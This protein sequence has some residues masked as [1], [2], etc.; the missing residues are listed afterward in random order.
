[1][2]ERLLSG[3]LRLVCCT[4]QG[5]LNVIIENDLLGP[6]DEFGGQASQRGS[7]SNRSPTSKRGSV[8]RASTKKKIKSNFKVSS[9][10]QS[11]DEGENAAAKSLLV[12][13]RRLGIL[14]S[15]LVDE[16]ESSH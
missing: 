8:A 10:K 15:S 7:D 5:S 6:M 12:D 9:R 14:S 1:M 16:A 3:R 11:R 13:E 4:C 2:N